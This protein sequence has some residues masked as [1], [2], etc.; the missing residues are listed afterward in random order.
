MEIFLKGSKE[1][2]CCRTSSKTYGNSSSPLISFWG[3]SSSETFPLLFT[4]S[5]ISKSTQ[6]I[7]FHVATSHLFQGKPILPP[8][9]AP[10]HLV[11]E[12]HCQSEKRVN[13]QSFETAEKL[14]RYQ[15][16]CSCHTG[17]W[18]CLLPQSASSTPREKGC[19]T[20]YKERDCLHFQGDK[21]C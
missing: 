5:Q 18:G 20:Y 1:S 13:K 3:F 19:G 6:F 2:F 14:Q 21:W 8:A 10:V 9:N 17:K 12:L 16:L 15:H 4:V 11:H 7:S